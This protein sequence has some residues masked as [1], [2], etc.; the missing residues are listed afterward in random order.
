MTRNKKV[1]RKAV[2][3]V[4]KKLDSNKISRVCKEIML[5]N[6]LKHISLKN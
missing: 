2:Q 6:A 3:I 1:K 4:K 5:F